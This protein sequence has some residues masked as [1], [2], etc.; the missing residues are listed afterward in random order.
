MDM[1]TKSIEE[2]SFL[3]YCEMHSKTP[4]ALFSIK[5]I[6]KLCELA[7]YPTHDISN[8]STPDFI[9]LPYTYMKEVLEE[10]YQRNIMA[11][12]RN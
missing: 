6:N 7:G 1:E 12:S 2:R 3:S 9:S 10:I 5:D 11:K 8:P 4:R